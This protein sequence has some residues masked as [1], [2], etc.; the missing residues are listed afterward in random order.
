MTSKDIKNNVSGTELAL[1]DYGFGL[2]IPVRAEC[3]LSANN[4][5]VGDYSWNG[6]CG[7]IFFVDLKEQMV[8]VMMGVAPGEI[9]KVHRKKPNALIYGAIEK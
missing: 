9:R 5:N 3:G 4:G 8:V 7:A 6:A 1:I 2:G